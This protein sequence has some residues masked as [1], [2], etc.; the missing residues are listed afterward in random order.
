MAVSSTQYLGGRCQGQHD[1]EDLSWKRY[2]SPFLLPR[3]LRGHGDVMEGLDENRYH[4]TK[5]E[6]SSFKFLIQEASSARA[7]GKATQ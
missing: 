5:I 1:T 7:E 3:N 2:S 6:P 4:L